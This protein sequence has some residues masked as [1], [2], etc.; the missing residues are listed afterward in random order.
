M[1]LRQ[2]TLSGTVRPSGW[3]VLAGFALAGL[4]GLAGSAT[5]GQAAVP[6]TA[7]GPDG[8]SRSGGAELDAPVAL[9]TGSTLG[10]GRE[11]AFELA[12]RGWHVIVHGRNEER[13]HEVVDS[14]ARLGTGS[15]RF[16]R[17]DFASLEEV[18]TLARTVTEEYDRLDLLVSNAGI[19]RPPEEGRLVSEDGHELHFQVNYLAGYLLVEELLPLVEAS[20]PS[21]IVKV[22]SVAQA[23]I[24]FDNVMLEEGYSDFHAY[25]QSKLAQIFHALDLAERL[26]GTDVLPVSVHPA[27]IMDTGMV[28]ERGMAARASVQ[29]GVEAVLAV[30]LGDDVVPG[31]WYRGLERAEPHDQ[32]L[33]PEA[34]A[35]L[36][37]LS[38]RLTGR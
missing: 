14:I 35:A 17:S 32:A 18:R 25:S 4:A 3:A 26:E 8:L 16:I 5:A 33:D 28:E 1:T 27:T 30:A 23:P 38:E 34:R 9:V 37:E 7:V 29:E 12:D 10:L 20:T 24:D 11:L 2:R 15:A 21:R 31:A 36:R 6:G 19:W 13:G 22:S